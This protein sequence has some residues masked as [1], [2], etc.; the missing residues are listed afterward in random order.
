LLVTVDPVAVEA[1]PVPNGFVFADETRGAWMQVDR[2]WDATPSPDW[3]MVA[4]GK[5][6][7]VQDGERDVPPARWTRLAREIG[8]AVARQLFPGESDASHMARLERELQAHK[9]A[10]SGMAIAWGIGIT[11][12]ERVDAIHVSDDGAALRV[13]DK[14]V[15]G[16]A[17]MLE[18]WR[19]RWTRG[20][21]TIG[22]GASPRGAQDFSPPTRWLLALPRPGA[23]PLD[24]T[25]DSS[26]FARVSWVQGP[27]LDISVNVDL[28]APVTINPDATTGVSVTGSGG[29]IRVQRRGDPAPRIIG[30][31]RPLAA[32][33]DARYV[34][35]LV[36]RPGAATYETPTI[37][38]VYQV[39]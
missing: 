36:L 37:V 19:V 39:P 5:A 3:R 26:R 13:P 31:G 27:T 4:Y 2:V 33:R 17:V 18:G 10:S 24:S 29:W 35:A 34:A 28:L 20:G 22:I 38:A 14:S 11:F 9:F 1:E 30:P 12:V 16:D 21:D 8:P 23:V 6:Y 25:A 32:T 15:V 7:V